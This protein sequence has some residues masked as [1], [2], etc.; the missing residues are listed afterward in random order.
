MVRLTVL[1]GRV[2]RGKRSCMQ[3]ADYRSQSCSRRSECLGQDGQKNVVLDRRRD[4]RPHVQCAKVFL[5]TKL[6]K[7][8]WEGIFDETDRTFR[9]SSGIAS[10]TFVYTFVVWVIYNRK[11]YFLTTLARRCGFNG[12]RI[13]P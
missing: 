13:R 10:C 9:A 6:K 12:F 5:E 7:N 3:F 2:E 8:Q 11:R 1:P 4:S